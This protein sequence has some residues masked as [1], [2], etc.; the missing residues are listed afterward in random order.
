[1]KDTKPKVS[2]VAVT[3]FST[4]EWPNGC[5][6]RQSIYTCVKYATSTRD[7]AEKH[8]VWRTCTLVEKML[9][10]PLCVS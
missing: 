6:G 7:G 1:M 8:K 2:S 3:A 4:E 5:G 10:F 9:S